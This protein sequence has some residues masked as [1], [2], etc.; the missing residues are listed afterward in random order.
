MTRSQPHLFE[1]FVRWFTRGTALYV[2]LWFAMLY[3]GDAWQ[4]M[5]V[6]WTFFGVAGTV[7]VLGLFADTDDLDRAR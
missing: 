4:G 5:T 1:R 2:V 6:L 3:V 7:V